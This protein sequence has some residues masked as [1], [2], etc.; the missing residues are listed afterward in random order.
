[1]AKQ[2]EVVSGIDHMKGR[3]EPG[4]LYTGPAKSVG[5]LLECGAIREL[6]DD[7]PAGANAGSS[8]SSSEE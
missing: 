7:A 6:N 3:D 8:S 4:D 5:W 1:M 2:Y